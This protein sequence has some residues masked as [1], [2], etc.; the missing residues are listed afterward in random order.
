VAGTIF[1]VEFV[2]GPFDG[3]LQAFPCAPEGRVK[4]CAFPINANTLPVLTGEPPGPKAPITSVAYY[5][6][7]VTSGVWWYHFLGSKSP[8][9]WR[10]MSGLEQ[11]SR[12]HG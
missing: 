9:E 7:C 2:G 10:Q 6:L 5:E 12:S 3:H 8:E 11:Q 4:T 1:W